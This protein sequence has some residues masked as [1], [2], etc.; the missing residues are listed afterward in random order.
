MQ[1][2]FLRREETVHAYFVLKYRE[3]FHAFE[4][5]IKE[6]KTKTY[7][8]ITI[9]WRFTTTLNITQITGYCSIHREIYKKMAHVH[10]ASNVCIIYI[11]S[12]KMFMLQAHVMSVGKWFPCVHTCIISAK[13]FMLLAY[14]R[15]SGKVSRT[16]GNG[17]RATVKYWACQIFPYNRE[18]FPVGPG[19]FCR[20]KLSQ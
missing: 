15:R 12:V 13:R 5:Y 8:L 17:S 2:E 19:N 1:R 11:I 6:V 9:G 14:D 18:S 7:S 10:E 20:F 4:G 3:T 16:T